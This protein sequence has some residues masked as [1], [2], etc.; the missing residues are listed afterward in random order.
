MPALEGRQERRRTG[1]PVLRGRVAVEASAVA[2]WRG[3]WL[4]FH[5]P[6]RSPIGVQLALSAATAGG[7]DIADSSTPSL[8]SDLPFAVDRSPSNSRT[9]APLPSQARPAPP[10]LTSTACSAST[11]SSISFRRLSR[12]RC[13]PS[14]PRLAKRWRRR[15]FLVV[16]GSAAASF[17]VSLQGLYARTA[18]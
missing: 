2:S 5:P 1:R 16:V 8:P 7:R 12:D 6:N 9:P 3:D 15:S 10:E 17:R 14:R 13:A 18:E 11:W 4:S